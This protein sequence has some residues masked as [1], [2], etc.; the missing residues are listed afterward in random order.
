MSLWPNWRLKVKSYEKVI[1]DLVF[2]CA[3]AGKRLAQ[4]ITV[5]GAFKGLRLFYKPATDTACGA[6]MLVHQDEPAP[7]G[8]VEATSDVISGG[9]PYERYFYWVK[10]R[11]STLPL[12][13]VELAA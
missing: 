1:F 3:E 8:Y 11:V 2:D 9:V 5:Y 6:L 12:L 7:E 4:E 13:A 10:Q